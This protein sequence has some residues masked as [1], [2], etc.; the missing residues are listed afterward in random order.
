MQDQDGNWHDDETMEL[1]NIKDFAESD[2]N[3]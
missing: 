1:M 3:T 2:F